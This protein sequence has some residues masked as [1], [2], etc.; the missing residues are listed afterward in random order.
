MRASRANTL[1]VGVLVLLVVGL[2]LLATLQFRWIDQVSEAEELRMRASVELAARQLTQDLQSEL[3]GIVDAFAGPPDG[4]LALREEEWRRT[5]RYPGLVESIAVDR[6]F[7]D[8]GPPFDPRSLEI[9]LG[10]RR[11]RPEPRPFEPRE[12]RPG[13]PPGDPLGGRREPPPERG[14]A[15][16][17]PPQVIVI[18]LDREELTSVVLP[19]LARRHFADAYDVAIVSREGVFFRTDPAWPDGRTAP[20]VDFPVRLMG[21]PEQGQGPRHDERDESGGWHLLVRR[22]DGGLARVVAAA[23]RRNLAVSAGILAILIST[24]AVLLYLLRR[25]DRLREQQTEF[26]AAISHELNTPVTALRS[27]GENL[28]D[29]I[30]TDPAKLAR[31]GETI[32][33][34]SA[35]LGDMIAQV[36]EFAGMRARRDRGANEPVDVESVIE[37]A[38]AQSRWVIDGDSVR[39][40]TDIQPNLPRPRG[41]ARALTRAVQNLVANAIRHGGSGG[42]VGVRAYR[43]GNAKIAITVEDRGPGIDSRDAAHLFEPF[44]RGRGTSAVRGSGLGLTIVQQV[45]SAHGGTIEIQRRRREGAAFTMTLPLSS[46]V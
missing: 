41:D 13:P 38:V 15:P 2:A 29:G 24:V 19:E 34:E 22:H 44:Y 7:I 30:I 10:D 26:V 8:R 11:G 27:A 17:G 23:R 4:D 45:V 20:D 6:R 32:V 21:P 16:P 42:W 31:Y 43:E 1:L 12:R 28:K 39:V 35:R 36:L 33:K 37:E 18:K 9:V 25:A 14:D 46:H 3:R 40:E 5:A